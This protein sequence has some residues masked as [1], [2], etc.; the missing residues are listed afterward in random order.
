M[1]RISSSVEYGMRVM[2]RLARANGGAPVT[3]ESLSVTENVPKDY[4]D[5]ILRR[6]RQ[7]GLI[8]SV[9]G[10]AGGYS[11]AK[12][13]SAIRIGDVVRALEQQVF[14]GVCERFSDGQLDCRHQ[15]N[16]GLSSV[17]NRLG[18][19]IGDYLDSVTLEQIVNKE[20]A[21]WK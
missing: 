5:Q 14:E 6:L 19:M 17:W 20:P 2:T 18:Q 11:L 8:A 21:L 9:R 7:A 10:P 15:G 12:P 4:V 16:C 3:S 13:A 1:M